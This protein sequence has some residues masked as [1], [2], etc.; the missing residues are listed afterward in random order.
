MQILVTGQIQQ[1]Q[2]EYVNQQLLKQSDI[3]FT[4]FMLVDDEP[5]KGIKARRHR[6][7]NNHKQ[8]KAMVKKIADDYD[9][10]IQIEGDSE[11]PEDCFSQLIR[12]LDEVSSEDLGYISGVQ[13]G[14]HGLYCIGAWHFKDDGFESIDHKK[15]GLIEVDATGF[16][17]LIAP[18]KTWLN[19]ICSWTDEYW[20]PDVNW[21]RSLRSQGYKIYADM[22]LKIGHK[23]NAGIIDFDNQN[24]CRAEFK[25]IDGHWKYK[26]YE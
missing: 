2:I 21:G 13:I 4:N 24:L 17:C 10:I 12:R 22:D 25:Q 5:E 19:G 23:S 18:V 20:G 14:R 15:T 11:L 7:A 9:Y 1:D 16:Y 8:L 26:V 3:E 6:I